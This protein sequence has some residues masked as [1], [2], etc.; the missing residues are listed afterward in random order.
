MISVFDSWKDEV[1][2]GLFN[3]FVGDDSGDGHG[4]CFRTTIAWPDFV[5]E[6]SHKEMKERFNEML[7]KGDEILQ[8][9]LLSLCSAYGDSE[10]PMSYI[11]RLLGYIEDM[12]YI[13][14]ADSIRKEV[15][16]SSDLDTY[17]ADSCTWVYL[18]LWHAIVGN[19]HFIPFKIV[20][21]VE[22]D[23][24]GYGFFS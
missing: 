7:T 22:V 14:E 21:I 1:Q 12:G 10:I 6:F 13:D 2:P 18:I 24:G 20:N 15:A 3:I 9:Q 19:G 11:N 23:G 4:H 17:Y 8:T 16:L 5:P